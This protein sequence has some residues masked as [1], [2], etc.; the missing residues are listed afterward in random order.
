MGKAILSWFKNSPVYKSL[1]DGQKEQA[2][3]D[4]QEIIE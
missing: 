2:L 1:T 3:A 4:A